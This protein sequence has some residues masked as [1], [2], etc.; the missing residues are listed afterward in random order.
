VVVNGDVPASK[1]VGPWMV[2]RQ[3]HAL[4]RQV[5]CRS[6]TDFDL[7]TCKLW[8]ITTLSLD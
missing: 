2:K 1:A 6:N 4:A 8:G 5:D 3:S 7:K